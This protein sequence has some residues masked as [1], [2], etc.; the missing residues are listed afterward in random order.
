MIPLVYL[1]ILLYCLCSEFA[2]SLGDVNAKTFDHKYHQ[3]AACCRHV[4][5]NEDLLVN[6]L[7]SVDYGTKD[8]AVVSY[9]SSSD[10]SYAVYA[11]TINSA[12]AEQNDYEMHLLNDWELNESQYVYNSRYFVSIEFY[13]SSKTDWLVFRWNGMRLLEN[14]LRI[15]EGWLTAVD[16]VVWMVGIS[17]TLNPLRFRM[18]C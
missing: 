18:Y 11:F 3:T 1:L 9:A 4:D 17:C 6:C 2:L 13:F 7:Q 15:D 5:V 14:A 10:L 8:I 12:F 16:Y